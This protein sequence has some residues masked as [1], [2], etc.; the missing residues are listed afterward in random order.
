MCWSPCVPQTRRQP[1]VLAGSC[2]PH[3]GR[4]R[5]GPNKR[6][7][8]LQDRPRFLQPPAPEGPRDASTLPWPPVSGPRSKVRGRQGDSQ[9]QFSGAP[10]R[11]LTPLPHRRWVP[12][13][14]PLPTGF[15]FDSDGLKRGDLQIISSAYLIESV[16]TVNCQDEFY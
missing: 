7:P 8:A 11:V 15:T 10:G 3:K 2:C 1:G 4:F 5:P 16:G 13:A 6:L 9:G 14:A 12:T